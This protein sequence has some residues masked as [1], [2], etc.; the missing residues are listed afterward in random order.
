VVVRL[1]PESRARLSQIY[2]SGHGNSFVLL[3]TEKIKQSY[4]KWVF[5][6]Y[7]EMQDLSGNYTPASNRDEGPGISGQILFTT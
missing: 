5:F 7:I 6:V 2:T 3:L 4:I 1:S